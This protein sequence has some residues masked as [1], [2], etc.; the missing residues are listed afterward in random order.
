M[1]WER[2]RKEQL[3]A[4][5]N[6]EYTELSA[7]KAQDNNL[8]DELE[9]LVGAKHYQ[10]RDTVHVLLEW[11]QS[12]VS[13]MYRIFLFTY[14]DLGNCWHF[15]LCLPSSLNKLTAEWLNIFTWV[16]A[17]CFGHMMWTSFFLLHF[18]A[19]NGHFFFSRILSKPSNFWV[20]GF[21]LVISQ[22]YTAITSFTSC[23]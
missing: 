3:L 4:E 23:S 9:S 5:K 20:L 18:Y 10:S 11:I 2:Q 8:K 14:L 13:E 17:F 15:P 19:V 6:R 16:A 7:L 1:E 12:W 21:L 22:C